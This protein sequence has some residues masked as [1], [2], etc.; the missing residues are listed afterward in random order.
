M[1][2]LRRQKKDK[3]FSK[4]NAFVAEVMER[5]YDAQ[6]RRLEKPLGAFR[7]PTPLLELADAPHP[8]PYMRKV[9]RAREALRILVEEGELEYHNLNPQWA[10]QWAFE[11]EELEKE[12]PD[13]DMWAA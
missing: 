10:Y 13:C 7:A 5:W 8:D 1:Q 4:S 6:V 11:E 12:A 9:D 3:H 2:A